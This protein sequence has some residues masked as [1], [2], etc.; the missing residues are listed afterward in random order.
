V[1]DALQALPGSSAGTVTVHEVYTSP[2]SGVA[3]IDLLSSTYPTPFT[4]YDSTYTLA[5]PGVCGRNDIYIDADS[6]AADGA[7]IPD[8]TASIAGCGVAIVDTQLGTGACADRAGNSDIEDFIGS[9]GTYLGATMTGITSSTDPYVIALVGAGGRETA[10]LISDNTPVAVNPAGT[11]E[12]EFLLYSTATEPHEAV[13]YY[14]Y[15]HFSNGDGADTRFPL[16]EDLSTNC[17]AAAGFYATGATYHYD[18]L[19]LSDGTVPGLSL[20][21]YFNSPA[22]ET[23]PRVDYSFNN[24]ASDAFTSANIFNNEVKGVGVG[25]TISSVSGGSGDYISHSLVEVIDRGGDRVWDVSFHG[26]QAFF[27]ED[28]SDTSTG[29][30]T[31]V[32]AKRGLCDYSSG[33]CDCFSGFTGANCATQNALAF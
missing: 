29:V 26:R 33:L 28:G 21:L 24:M 14:Q 5:W 6:I 15:P 30:M 10:S 13:I 1:R 32:C 23:A 18:A 22:L 9:T 27:L 31:H 19:Q 16:F 17:D 20:F 7:V 11:N 4:G 2:V 25:E 8:V 12:G 3:T